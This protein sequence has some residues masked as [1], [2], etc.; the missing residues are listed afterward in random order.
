MSQ[1]IPVLMYH[2][3]SPRP[4]LVTVSP[5][6]F[7]AQMKD[8]V[9]RGYVSLRADQFL[10][11]MENGAPV[12]EKAVLI[13]FDDGYLD[14]YVYAFPVLE[15]LNLTA[16]VFAV[17][18][19][20]GDGPARPHAGQS[21]PIPE[22][23]DHKTCKKLIRGGRAD[24]VMMRWSEIE[25]VETAGSMEIH[26]HTHSH[27]RWDEQF[28]PNRFAML[29]QDLMESRG[30]L[31]QR[32]GTSPHLCWPWG[33][34]EPGYVERAQNLGFRALYTVKKGVNVAGGDPADIR[35]FVVKDK[36]GI[37]LALRLWLYRSSIR[38][39]LYSLLRGK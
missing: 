38:G 19:W 35:R 34:H 39:R 26:S 30:M 23:P 31:L 28:G 25:I 16:T 18:S 2:H 36:A 22:T 11:F 10:D 5:K 8:L 15:R 24:A 21:G 12:P 4:G 6:T 1:S 9:K 32:L 3:V 13:T 27:I 7:E 20:I 14:N 37:W 33:Y 17:T 29:E